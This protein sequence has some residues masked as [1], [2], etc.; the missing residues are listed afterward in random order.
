M[1]EIE[2]VLEART[3]QDAEAREVCTDPGQVWTGLS[4]G[5][6]SEDN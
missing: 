1:N 3:N 6:C 2:I 5:V 4:S